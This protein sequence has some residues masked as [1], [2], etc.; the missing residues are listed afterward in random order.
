VVISELEVKQGLSDVAETLA[1]MH[2]SRMAHC[3]LSP[4]SILITS[5]GAWKL[6]GCG[7]VRQ[8]TQ[9]IGGSGVCSATL[10]SMHPRVQYSKPVYVPD[11]CHKA[12]WHPSCK[13]PLVLMLCQSMR[14]CCHLLLAQVEPVSH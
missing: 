2:K 10:Y 11:G 7:F 3:N 1:F 4:E 8:I 5:D 14:G 13:G 6:A 12:L 9:E